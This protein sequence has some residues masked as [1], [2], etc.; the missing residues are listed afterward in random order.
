MYNSFKV[1]ILAAILSIGWGQDL[2]R[3][4]YSP[5]DSAW[6]YQMDSLFV[7]GNRQP[8]LSPIARLTIPQ[9]RIE[10]MAYRDL[11]EV[12]TGEIPGIF[13]TEK[14]VMGYGVV[15]GS[16]GRDYP[17]T[18]CVLVSIQGGSTSPRYSP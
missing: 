2:P 6:V 12:I 5:R 16:A 11:N 15:G 10:A 14:G 7:V 13:G 4:Y 3:G 1:V 8:G 17:G 18:P 9:E